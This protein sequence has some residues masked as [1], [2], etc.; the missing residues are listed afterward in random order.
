MTFSNQ[1][2]YL[3]EKEKENVIFYVHEIDNVMAVQTVKQN[4]TVDFGRDTD[5]HPHV[6]VST[7]PPP[8][9]VCPHPSNS[10][11]S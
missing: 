1:T 2:R 8:N 6:S 7:P 3:M 9:L 4:I 10:L 5:A 11:E